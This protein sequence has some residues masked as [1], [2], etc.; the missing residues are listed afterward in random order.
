MPKGFVVTKWTDTDGLIVQLNYP[1]ELKVDLDD[2]MR[3]FYAHITGVA[4]AG[5]VLVRLEKVQSNVASYFTGMDSPTPFMINLILEL[6]EDPDMF[7]EAVIK[8]INEAILKYLRQLGTSISAN[9]EVVKKLKQYLKNAL[10]LLERLKYLTKEQLLAQIYY[11]QKGRKILELLRERAY[12]KKQLQA[13]LEESLKKI[14]TNLDITLDPF[15]K[16]GLVKQDWIEGVAE[17]FLFLISD[18][19]IFRAPAFDLIDNAKNNLPNPN[20]A[21]KYLSEV[22]KFFADYKPTEEDNLVLAR[23]LTNPDKFDYL[24]LFRDR[25]YPL[26]KIPKGTDE[27]ALDVAHLLSVMEKDNILKIIKDNKNVE[28]VFLLT[29][30][31]VRPFYPEY[32]LENI[33]KDQ[34][35]GIIKKETAIKHLDYLEKVYYDFHE[36]KGK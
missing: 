13:L 30:V 23:N 29:D 4:E 28:W 10:F 24:A 35:E 20:L 7:G 19:T 9:Y 27:G 3:V 5:N 2:M 11:S 31:A 21:E 1:E 25:P 15:V 17:V 22:K 36:K 26:N 14:I 6:G 32:M 8:D 33:R 16:S 34:E 18:F 12:S